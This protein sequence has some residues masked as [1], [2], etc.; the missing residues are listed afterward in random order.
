MNTGYRVHP[1]F[2][3]LKSYFHLIILLSLNVSFVVNPYIE[4][5]CAK[6]RIY[7]NSVH[8]VDAPGMVFII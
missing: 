8:L 3:T 6:E 1:E 4:A 7:S 5:Q 2:R